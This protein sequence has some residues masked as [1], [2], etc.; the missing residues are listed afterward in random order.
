MQVVILAGG[1]GTRLR[2]LTY[3]QPKPMISINGKPFL[4]YQLKLVKSFGLTDVVILVGYLANQVEEYFGNGSLLGLSIKYS[5]EK[6]LLGTGGALKNAQDVL[7]QEFLLLNGDTF[8]PVDYGELIKYFYKN[9]KM[10]VITA[11]NN[12]NNIASSNITIGEAN[13]VISYD[14]KDSRGKTHVDAGAI[15]L[16]KDVLG[17]IPESL[18]CSLEEEVFPKLIQ[19]KQLLAFPTNQRF[20]DIGSHEGLSIIKE[21]L[22]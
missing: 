13:S 10:V 21:I 5:Y 20:Y 15:I 2:P 8:L 19:M 12:H 16:K 9:N 11:Y 3:Q 14:K 4:E 1:K 18:A 22:K 7:A 17:I 6:K